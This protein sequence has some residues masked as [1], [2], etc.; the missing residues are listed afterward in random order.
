[1]R[2]ASNAVRLVLVVMCS[3]LLT[4]AA[5]CADV[6]TGTAHLAANLKP[7]PLTGGVIKDAMLTDTELSQ[8]FD[9]YFEIVGS[10]AFGGPAQLFWDW[11]GAKQSDCAGLS[12]ILMG[13]TYTNAQVL[14]VAREMWWNSHSRLQPAATVINLEEGM[15]ALPTMAAAD[16]LFAKFTEQWKRCVGARIAVGVNEH[17]EIGEV[18][19]DASVVEAT[20]ENHDQDILLRESHALGVRDNC[21]VEVSIVYFGD[22]A[23][24]PGKSAS[25][26]ARQMVNKIG[27]RA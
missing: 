6:V 25:D 1:M 26:V 5:G 14:T 9:Q 12:H 19:A 18:H 24:A 11:P 4:V 15:V 21:I 22:T 23:P 10:P 8:L 27:D 16:A 3:V 7:H 13:E 17:Y 2:L 20:V